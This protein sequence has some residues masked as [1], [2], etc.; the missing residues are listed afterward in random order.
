MANETEVRRSTASE[1]TAECRR[2][3]VC[4]MLSPGKAVT[5]LPSSVNVI[6]SD[7]ADPHAPATAI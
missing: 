2:L 1:I 6:L 7:I 5:V 3:A 4:Q